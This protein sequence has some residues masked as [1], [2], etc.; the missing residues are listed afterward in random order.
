MAGAI[1][2]LGIYPAIGLWQAIAFI[3]FGAVFLFVY[4]YLVFR[5]ED[6]GKRI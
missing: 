1:S 4:S 6:K 5:D 3:L 2:I